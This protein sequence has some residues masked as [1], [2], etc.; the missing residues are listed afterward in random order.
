M[1]QSLVAVILILAGSAAAQAGPREDALRVVDAW[2]RA[3]SASDIEAMVGLYD[4]DASFVG[5]G[6]RAVVT[7]PEGIRAYF[8]RGFLTDRPRAAKVD[9]VSVTVLS[10]TA[11][12]VT[13]LDT[14]SN[15]RA[16]TVISRS[17]RVTFVVAKRGSDWKI[18]HFHRSAMPG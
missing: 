12:V 4:P 17:G 3:F 14:V 9:G 1:R 16:G 10:D 15:T 13:G 11:A 2:T 18:V 7:R 5:T 6:S 8:E